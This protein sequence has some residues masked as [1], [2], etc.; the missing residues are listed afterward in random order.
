MVDM[1]FFLKISKL[2]PITLIFTLCASILAQAQTARE[3]AHA[4]FPSVVLILA[5]Q[6]KGKTISLGSGFFVQSDV[7]ATNYH[8]I[9]GSAHLYIKIV[10]Q[11]DIYS[12][13]KVLSVD[14]KRD[15]ALLRV[16]DIEAP[17]LS[18]A[19]DSGVEV[20]DEVYTIGN[21]EGLEGTLSQGI[22]SGIRQTTAG[23]Y[24]QITAPI[25]H[26]SSGG[27][28]LNKQGQV[29]GIAVGTFRKGQNLNF[30]IPVSDLNILLGRVTKDVDYA[31]AP[32]R[33]SKKNPPFD[34][35]APLSA[36]EHYK[37]GELYFSQANYQQA[38]EEYKLAALLKLEYAEAYY[39]LGETYLR[40]QDG[41]Q[42]LD[43]YKEAIKIKPDY[44]EAHTGLG[45][46]Y[47]K[48]ERYGE[49]IEATEVAIRIKPTDSKAF[50]V[51]GI[52]YFHLAEISKDSRRVSDYTQKSKNSLTQAILF[53]S[54][55]FYAYSWLGS[56]YNRENRYDEELATYKKALQVF[57]ASPELANDFMSQVNVYYHLSHFYESSGRLS[58]GIEIFSQIVKLRPKD[59]EAYLLMGELYVHAKDKASALK[60]Y[61]TLQSVDRVKASLLFAEI[62]K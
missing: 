49:A 31:D 50:L 48:L 35:Q 36:E 26:G 43:A 45:L 5:P 30:A 44:A 1:R 9:K 17:P 34:K 53:D 22:V 25:S 23:K 29:I 33:T 14:S 12:V 60:V 3:V 42:A 59:G 37:L 16:Q 62:N 7:I 6:I 52:I 61:E 38:A 13:A 40:L 20:G 27:P 11:E 58:E 54:K 55:N 18:L 2:L 47:I 41:I 32:D 57:L 51:L 39:G 4:S 28:V 10:G 19:D 56:L 21:P 15:L 24:L 8:V 46:S